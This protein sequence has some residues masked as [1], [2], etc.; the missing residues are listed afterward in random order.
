MHLAQS[1][2][3]VIGGPAVKGTGYLGKP[4]R[5]AGPVDDQDGRGSHSRDHEQH[6]LAQEKAGVE[7]MF[8]DQASQPLRPGS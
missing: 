2:H 8:F 5:G 4:W 3:V 7:R 6:T 1:L